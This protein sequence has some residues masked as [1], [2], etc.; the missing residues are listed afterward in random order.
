[1]DLSFIA[2]PGSALVHRIDDGQPVALDPR[3]AGL[4]ARA[5]DKRRRD[6]ALGRAC[7]RAAL[8]RHGIED[9]AVGRADSGAPLWPQGMV[10]S[11]THTHGFAAALA[12]QAMTFRALGIDAERTG[13]MSDALAPRLFTP[14]ERDRL[15]SLDAA[16][17]RRMATLL[18]SAKEACYKLLH[19]LTGLRLDFRQ[20]EVAP[21]DGVFTVRQADGAQAWAGSLTGRYVILSDLVVT[22]IGLEAQAAP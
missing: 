15:S 7:A 22:A 10:G 13:G 3:E 18:F 19:P 21:G 17:R 4:V 8:A 16:D 5:G 20:L 11:I 2:P 6:F 1:M 12:G 14:G 9:A